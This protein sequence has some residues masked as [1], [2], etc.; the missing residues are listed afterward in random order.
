LANE[1]SPDVCRGFFYLY[2]QN[3]LEGAFRHIF[4]DDFSRV[5]VGDS[6]FLIFW[7]AT[8]RDQGS[9]IR[10]QGSG[11]RDQGKIADFGL[12]G[13]SGMARGRYRGPS[14]RSG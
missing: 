6:R 4:E 9:G 13:A 12:T 2:F 5:F 10:D 8:D 14:L 7:G 1:K 11:I 3:R